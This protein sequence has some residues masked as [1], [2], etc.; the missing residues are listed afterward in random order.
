MTNGKSFQEGASKSEVDDK[1]HPED[2]EKEKDVYKILV[3]T[4][5]YVENA[6]GFSGEAVLNNEE[7]QEDGDII[8]EEL[9]GKIQR[10]S[11]DPYVWGFLLLTLMTVWSIWFVL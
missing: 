9:L 5:T 10:L 3:F 6:G 1:R 8:H 7:Q 11:R 4:G 2:W